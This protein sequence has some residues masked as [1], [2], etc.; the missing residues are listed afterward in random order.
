METIR[1]LRWAKIVVSVASFGMIYP[2]AIIDC[3]KLQPLPPYTDGSPEEA[4][5]R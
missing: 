1:Y 5:K 3:M 4:P 2:N